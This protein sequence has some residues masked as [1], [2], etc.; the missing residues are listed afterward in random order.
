MDDDRQLMLLH[1]VPLLILAGLYGLVSILIGFSLL[2][3]RR[4]SGLGV[5][6]WLLFTVVAAIAALL[7][8]LALTGNDPLADE[9][10]WLVVL[11]AVAIAVPGVLVLVRGHDRSLLVTALRR[12]REAEELATERG[13]EA[14]AISRLST[15]LSGSQSGEEAA[16]LLFDEVAALL[17]P[18]AL[19]LA[20]V[21]VELGNAVDAGRRGLRGGRRGRHA[22]DRL[23][24]PA[25]QGRQP[26]G[27][28]DG[29]AD[30]GHVRSLAVARPSLPVILPAWLVA[31]PGGDLALRVSPSWAT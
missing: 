9:P 22:P 7:A 26:T 27:A 2:R 25:R 11:S 17:G 20:H 28:P 6:I 18:D 29:G 31:S 3:E 30:R 19:L 4:A 21:D 13:R 16:A 5:G 8:G 1:A 12:V 23:P 24:D 15:A 14:D 10:S